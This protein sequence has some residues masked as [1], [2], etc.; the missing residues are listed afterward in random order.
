MR[1]HGHARSRQGRTTPNGESRRRTFLALSS[2]TWFTIFLSCSYHLPSISFSSK[3]KPMGHPLEHFLS[4]PPSHLICHGNHIFPPTSQ[5]TLR[6]NSHLPPPQHAK[7]S[8]KD[9]VRFCSSGH[10][11][12]RKVRLPPSLLPSFKYRSLTRGNWNWGSEKQCYKTVSL[13]HFPLTRLTACPISG[14]RKAFNR[15]E[16]RPYADSVGA[17]SGLK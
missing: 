1:E 6:P 17:V 12:C 13:R 3:S 9:P 10:C 11:T 2:S 7:K 5:Q 16:V 8:S 14:C 15:Y 4:P